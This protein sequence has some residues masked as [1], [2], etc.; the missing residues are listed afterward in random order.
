MTSAV[1]DAGDDLPLTIPAL[2]RR[3]C[4]K[5]ADRTLLVCDEARLSYGEADVRS[6]R[7]ARGLL[8]SRRDKGLPRCPALSEWNRF[9]R[10]PSRRSENRGR[11]RAFEHLIHRR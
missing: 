8:A 11:G 7:L 9:H 10:R 6:R 5:H 2:W 1:I 3:Q 4:C